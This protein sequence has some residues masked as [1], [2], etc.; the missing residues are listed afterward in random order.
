MPLA[1]GVFV[2]VFFGKAGEED[3]AEAG[4][5]PVEVG[6]AHVTEAGLGLQERRRPVRK[7][8]SSSWDQSK[9]EL[10][11]DEAPPP[12]AVW[13][14]LVSSASSLLPLLNVT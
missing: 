13:C 9:A 3:A 1:L 8:S 5:E 7:T 6:A 14:G 10:A 11:A 4:V 2:D 12:S